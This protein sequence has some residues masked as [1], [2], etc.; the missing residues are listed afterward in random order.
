M[1]FL[2]VIRVRLKYDAF[3]YGIS[4]NIPTIVLDNYYSDECFCSK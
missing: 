4:F 2:G 1:S 3:K